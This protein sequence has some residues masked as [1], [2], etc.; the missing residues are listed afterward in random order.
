MIHKTNKQ[1]RRQRH[2]L[3]TNNNALRI[4]DLC[5]RIFDL[6]SRI[7]DLCSTIFDLCPRIFDLSSRILDLSSRIFYLCSRIFNNYQQDNCPGKFDLY[8]R[9]LNI[10]IFHLLLRIFNQYQKDIAEGDEMPF[11]TLETRSRFFHKIS[12]FETRSRF[13]FTESQASR[14]DRD[15]LSFD[16][17][18]RDKIEIFQWNFSSHMIF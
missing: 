6:C 18:I 8:P 4:F 9:I 11:L 3:T 13:L 12:G 17:E 10:K 16:L 5:P 1:W 14:R 15:F 7:F 2:P